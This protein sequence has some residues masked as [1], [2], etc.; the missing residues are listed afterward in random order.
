[1]KL[2]GIDVLSSP[3]PTEESPGKSHGDLIAILIRKALNLQ[4]ILRGNRL[5]EGLAYWG[6]VTDTEYHIYI[7]CYHPQYSLFNS[8]IFEFIRNKICI[9]IIKCFVK[10]CKAAK[11][12]ITSIRQY[13]HWQKS[14]I[15]GFVDLILL[16]PY[17]RT[18]KR[19]FFQGQ[20]PWRSRSEA[21]FSI[22]L[23]TTRRS[24]IGQ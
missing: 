7:Y 9:N 23:E 3:K 4:Q 2:V 11:C 20:S 10:I 14:T 21:T 1:M 6:T 18:F 5:G 15:S 8:K 13:N 19:L 17:C 12:R 22:S 16:K 24:D